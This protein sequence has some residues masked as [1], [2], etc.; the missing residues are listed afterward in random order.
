MSRTLDIGKSVIQIEAQSL[1]AL[2]D[3]INSSF[4]KAVDIIADC[5]GKIICTGIGKSGHVA[6]KLASTFS[7][8]GTPAVFMHPA[9]SSHGDLGLITKD[10]L[11]VAISY[12][13]ETTE[14]NP[15]L[16]TVSRRGVVLIALTGI[17]NSSLGKGA[18]VSLDVSVTR[19]ACPLELAP[20]ASSTASMAMADALAMAVMDKKGFSAENFAENHPGGSLGFKLSQVKDNMHTGAG[21]VLVKKDTSLRVVFSKMSLA[22]SR[23]AAGV[24]DDNGDLIGII[25]DGDIRRRIENVEDPLKGVAS[26]MMTKNPRTVGCNEI[27]EKALF[28]MEQFRINVLFV[29]DHQSIKPKNPVGI[30][31]IQDL[32]RNRVR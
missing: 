8:T 25:T 11:V 14:L 26:D 13:G 1:L 16:N 10:D 3:R 6:R 12:G 15:I 29:Q 22:E 24:I 17:L 9:E 2:K 4:E 23:G 27:A 21:F 5:K 30:L 7:S 20:T 19:E 31:H 28:L 32:L 18:T